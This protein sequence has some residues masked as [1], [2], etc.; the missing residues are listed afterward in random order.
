MP[1][2]RQIKA[3]RLNGAKSRGPQ[4]REGK[5]VSRL[6]AMRFGIYS[7]LV[8]VDGENE[9]QLIE[10]GRRLRADLAPVGEMELVLADKIVSTSWRLRRIVQAE[11][12]L[13]EKEGSSIKA[14]TGF[15]NENMHRISRHE[16]QLERTLYRALHELQRIQDV[17]FGK[18]VPSAEAIDITVNVADADGDRSKLGSFRQNSEKHPKVVNDAAYHEEHP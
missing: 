17:R 4:T 12:M 11:A 16:A 9:S 6:N 14:F 13:Y 8:L 7:E 15:R 2:E 5:A 1:T 10:L 18:D 3:N